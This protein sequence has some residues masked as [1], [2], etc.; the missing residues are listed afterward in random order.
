MC[1]IGKAFINNTFILKLTVCSTVC[2][3][4]YFTYSKIKKEIIQNTKA[5]GKNHSCSPEESVQIWFCFVHLST[6]GKGSK[7]EK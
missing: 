6:K 4:Y 3:I 7:E 5:D 2:K 1:W